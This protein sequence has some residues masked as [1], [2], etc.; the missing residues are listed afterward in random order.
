MIVQVL[1][2]TSLRWLRR[3]K[4]WE[5]VVYGEIVWE[6][7]VYGEI[8]FQRKICNGSGGQKKVIER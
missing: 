4:R 5:E 2:D 6:E 1:L 7:V 3:K 8:V